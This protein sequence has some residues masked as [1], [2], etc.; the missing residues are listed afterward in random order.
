MNPAVVVDV[1][2]ALGPGLDFEPDPRFGLIGRR[3][4]TAGAWFGFDRGALAESDDGNGRLVP[5]VVG[6]PASTF[7]GARLLVELAG[8]W[9]TDCGIVLFGRV[10]GTAEPAEPLARIA[11]RIADVAERLDAPQAAREAK[12]ARQRHR[13]RRSAARIVGG[14]AWYAIDVDEPAEARFETPHSVAEYSLRRLPPR[15]IRGLEGLLDPEERILYWVERP[16]LTEAGILSRLRGLDRRAALLVLTDRQLLWIVDHAQPDRF[17]SDWGVDV[18]VMPVERVLDVRLGGGGELQDVTV[19]TRAG[20]LA[21]RLPVELRTE[22]EVLARLLFRFAPSGA[23]G[24][25]MR[26]YPIDLL[27][28]DVETAT[29]YGQAVEAEQLHRAAQAG[30][31]VLGFLYA[32]RRERQPEAASLILRRSQ[33]ELLTA[34]AR[35]VRQLDAVRSVRVTLSPLV[36]RIDFG[37]GLAISYPAP[38]ATSAAALVRLARRLL[39]TC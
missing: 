7:K 27:D 19:S 4:R 5:V 18:E 36:G 35:V 6:A 11:A 28:W 38:L 23:T 31:E 39:A 37:D 17:Q 29:R 2:E 22:A 32:P 26:I 20:P 3:A 12:H 9:R 24:P 10:P 21:Y 8:G 14:R 25:P 30:G 1:E 13:Q 34:R 16:A 15:F 33:V